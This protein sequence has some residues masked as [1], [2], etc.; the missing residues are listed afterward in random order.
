MRLKDELDAAFYGMTDEARCYLVD[1]AKAMRKNA[2]RAKKPS[3]SI[4][5]CGTTGLPLG[6]GASGIEDSVA[7]ELGGTPE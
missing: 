4:V 1:I 6:S 2:P 7:P 5:R 3:L